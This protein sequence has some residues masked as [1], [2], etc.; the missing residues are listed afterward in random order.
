[1]Q[2]TL[3]I[4]AN[5]LGDTVLDLFKNLTEEQK[6]EIATEILTNWLKNP[7]DIE[8]K[9]NT[10]EIVEKVRKKNWQM[11]ELSYDEIIKSAFFEEESKKFK[12][13]KNK[14]VEEIVEKTLDFYKEEIKDMVEKDEM[15]NK[16]KNE[17]L[18]HI[19]DNF[20]T[21]VHDAMIAWFC[22]GMNQVT[23]G[24]SQALHNSGS[25]MENV[26]AIIEHLNNKGEFI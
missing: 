26:Q 12:T 16:V 15:I 9:A 21:Y 3:N 19:K 17:V 6:K 11:K 13:S 20:R 2:I 7:R 22:Q 8:L 10:K 1:M 25:N 5:Q 23:Q 18:S 24:V 4:E 14:M